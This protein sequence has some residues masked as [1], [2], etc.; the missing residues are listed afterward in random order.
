MKAVIW[1][2]HVVYFLQL[3]MLDVKLQSKILLNH[4][5]KNQFYLPGWGI[6]NMCRNLTSCEE[7]SLENL[8]N[9]VF[10]VHWVSRT[11]LSP[12]TGWPDNYSYLVLPTIETLSP[13]LRLLL[14]IPLFFTGNCETNQTGP[15]CWQNMIFPIYFVR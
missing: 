12:R 4:E 15:L 8:P 6:F 11:P 3:N 14:A 1:L 7:P 10:K 9:R 2:V 13:V 5:H